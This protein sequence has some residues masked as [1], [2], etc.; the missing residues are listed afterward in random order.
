MIHIDINSDVGEGV[1]NESQLM[2]YLSSCNIACGGHAGT[3][4]TMLETLAFAKAYNVKI[5][6]HPSYPD[7]ANFG[8]KVMDISNTDLKI[9]IKHQIQGLKRLAKTTGQKLHHIKPHGAL[10]NLAAIDE[11][12]AEL[13]V[14]CILEI[15]D[16]LALFTPYQSVI[17]DVAHG[18]LETVIE[19]FADRAYN[20]DYTLAPREVK[21]AV[22][23][24]S[25]NV[26]SQVLDTMQH[27]QITTI[28]G[29]KIPFTAATFCVH[30]DTLNAV[31]IA[32]KLYNALKA[33]G[34]SM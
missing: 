18:K 21:G 10:Y 19:G 16:S 24:E 27:Q 11:T 30:S 5:G 9:A 26:I 1:G 29:V 20:E 15:D 23:T 31:N 33:E 7:A 17:F 25:E 32:R 4:K 8:R 22:L 13:M 3:K 12:I 2:P 6:A 34:F 28:N 14:Q